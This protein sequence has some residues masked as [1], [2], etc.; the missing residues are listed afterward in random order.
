M[1]F[2]WAVL[3][4]W[5]EMTAW[6]NGIKNCIHI[7]KLDAREGVWF[8]KPLILTAWYF[9]SLLFRQLQKNRS[10]LFIYCIKKGTSWNLWVTQKI[11]NLSYKSCLFIFHWFYI[12][13]KG[14]YFL[15]GSL[16]SLSKSLWK[17]RICFMLKHLMST[18]SKSV[19]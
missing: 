5:R 9:L 11:L 1:E 18:K 4:V 10:Q 6:R 12:E 17:F 8:L 19:G 15:W 2:K 7:S 3:Y 14:F 16:K 13:D